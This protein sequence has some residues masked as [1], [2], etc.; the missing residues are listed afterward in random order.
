M[1][2]IE[3]MY[4]ADE[5]R[6]TEGIAPKRTRRVE[7]SELDLAADLIDRLT[8]DFDHAK[9][10]DTY[11]ARLKKVIDAKRKGKELHTPTTGSPSLRR[12]DGGAAGEPRRLE[13]A[14]DE[15]E[16]EREAGE[17]PPGR[18]TRED[19][20]RPAQGDESVAARD[21]L[22][23]ALLEE[24]QQREEAA[25]IRKLRRPTRSAELLNQ[26]ARS[27]PK[28]V[29]GLTA[30]GDALRKALEAGKRDGVDAARRDVS[31]AIDQLLDA[32]RGEGP[33]EQVLA[34][35]ATSLQAAAADTEAGDRLREG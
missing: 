17:A 12:S 23:R 30:A 22:A 33:S 2:V 28:A 5:I 14:E 19:L 26:L 27:E 15:E 10:R 6:T 7:K 9:Y 16:G 31:A 21:V 24:D 11:R 35:V 18:V 1:L 25:A 20:L 3:R 4:F 34:E 8:G 13:E 29:T 32:A